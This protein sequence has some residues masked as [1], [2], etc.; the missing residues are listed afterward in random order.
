MIRPGFNVLGRPTIGT[1]SVNTNNTIIEYE[2]IRHQKRW[3]KR[4]IDVRKMASTSSKN[5]CRDSRC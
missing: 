1:P 5:M 2:N 3:D 4:A